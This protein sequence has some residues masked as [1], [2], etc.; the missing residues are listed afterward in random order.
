MLSPTFVFSISPSSHPAGYPSVEFAALCCQT[1]RSDVF[2]KYYG[3]AQLQQGY[4]VEQCTF[5]VIR[6]HDDPAHI[7]QLLLIV[8]PIY[9]GAAEVN[10]Q[11]G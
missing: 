1:H 8:I 11:C 9:V 5:N 3:R 2:G 7:L 10:C 4:V 6:V